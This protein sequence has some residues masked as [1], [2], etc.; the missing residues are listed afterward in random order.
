LRLK[1]KEAE[2]DES[3]AAAS[4]FL[5]DFCSS[6]APEGIIQA[7]DFSSSKPDSFI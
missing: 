2:S 5:A 3:H 1:R 7:L 6:V 4:A